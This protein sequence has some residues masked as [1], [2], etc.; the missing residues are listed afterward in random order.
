[1]AMSFFKNLS[2]FYP[3]YVLGGGLFE[4]L[5][6]YS[7]FYEN[8]M[9]KGILVLEISSL[10]WFTIYPRNNGFQVKSTQNH[11]MFAVS[12]AQVLNLWL[13]QQACMPN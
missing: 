2:I 5:E 3:F 8:G 1:M 13:L 6:A 4:K 10:H 7:S 12:I 9:L 11:K